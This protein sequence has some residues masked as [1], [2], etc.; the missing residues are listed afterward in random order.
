MISL[1][2]PEYVCG[3]SLRETDPDFA[4]APRFLSKPSPQSSFSELEL[5]WVLKVKEQT[6]LCDPYPHNVFHAMTQMGIG[7]F[8]PEFEARSRLLITYAR[9]SSEELEEQIR[10]KKAWQDRTCLWGKENL[11]EREP[12]AA[13]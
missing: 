9:L 13:F 11:Q 10:L 7:W 6:G 4:D 3:S 12:I 8:D 2:I 1:G 5:E